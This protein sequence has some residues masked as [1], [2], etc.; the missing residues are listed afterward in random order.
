MAGKLEEFLKGKGA[1]GLLR[2]DKQ[3]PAQGARADLHQFQHVKSPT[4]I[5]ASLENAIISVKQLALRCSY[6]VFHDKVHIANLDE[7]RTSES[8]DGFEQI[9]LLVRRTV[10]LKW[11]FDPG[12]DLICDALR[13]ECLDNSFDPVLDYLNGLVWDEVP[14][15]DKWLITY[16]GAEDTVLNRAFGRKT[17]IAGVRRVR[18]PGCKFDYMLVLEGP[19]GQGKSSLLAILA[20]GDD[21]F[22]DAEIIGDGKKD[23]QEAVQGI[24]IYEIGELEGM[25]KHD[26]TAIKLFLSKRYDKARPAYARSRVDRPRRCIFIGTTND[27]SYLRDPTGNRRVWPVKCK[28]MI[29]LI[30]FARDRDQ[31]WAEAAAIEASGEALTIGPELWGVAG[32]QQL[33]RVSHDPW[34][35]LIRE[36]LAGL[37][38]GNLRDGVSIDVD[39]NGNRQWRVASSYLLGM[40]VLGIPVDRQATAVTKRLADVMRSLGWT[41]PEQ[42]IRISGEPCRGYIKTI[43]TK[44]ITSAKPKLLTTESTTVVRLPKIIRR[45]V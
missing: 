41:K 32:V 34:E 6:D 19:Q 35:D 43:E 27:E 2:P 28:G 37:H 1:D 15:L 13:L 22:S 17:L 5:V 23:Q 45:L 30:G 25:S 11:G 24:W 38:A 44:Q 16:C 4:G 36:K 3:L 14:R 29:D 10:L 42:I 21:N 18:S 33:A 31:L 12:K 20:G 7:V 9:G 8:F 39:E 40:Y 26:V